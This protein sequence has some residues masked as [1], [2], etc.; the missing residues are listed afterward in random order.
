MSVYAGS[1]LYGTLLRKDPGVSKVSFIRLQEDEALFRP[2]SEAMFDFAFGLK[3]PLDPSIGYF[4]INFIN[5][6]V[7]PING[8]R[9][10][11]KKRLSF[12][13]CGMD[14]FNFKN[15]QDVKTFGIDKFY[16]LTD[17]DYSF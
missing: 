7:L 10:K 5:Q 3:A 13:I 16:C 15:K 2:Q 1:N 14:K 6:T 4:T 11:S 17:K 8:T 12:D 9:I